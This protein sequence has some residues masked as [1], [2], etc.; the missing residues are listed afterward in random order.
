MSDKD[1]III[2]AGEADTVIKTFSKSVRTYTEN[3]KEET[4]LLSRE[5]D[6]LGK[7]WTGDTFDLFKKGMT[8]RLKKIT[9]NTSEMENLTEQLDER[10]KEYEEYINILRNELN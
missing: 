2:M 6:E 8:E 7:I 4:D 3:M 9:A 1:D 10:S 5:V